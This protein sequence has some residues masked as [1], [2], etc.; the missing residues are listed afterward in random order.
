MVLTDVPC[1][2]FTDQIMKAENTGADAQ[3][4]DEI[5]VAETIAGR[6]VALT[7]AEVSLFERKTARPV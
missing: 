4:I 2:D 6:R 3:D 7:A 1:L 5:A